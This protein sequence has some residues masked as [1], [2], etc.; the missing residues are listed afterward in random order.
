[1]PTKKK[2]PERVFN[3]IEPRLVNEKP[4][5]KQLVTDKKRKEQQSTHIRCGST[6]H[7]W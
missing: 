4:K 1:M 2:I 5:V 6:S 7:N 3:M